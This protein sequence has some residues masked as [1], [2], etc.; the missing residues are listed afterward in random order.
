MRNRK[1][2]DLLL[3]VENFATGGQRGQVQEVLKMLIGNKWIA[4]FHR[5]SSSGIYEHAGWGWESSPE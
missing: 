5:R 4:D 3:E 1:H 2:E